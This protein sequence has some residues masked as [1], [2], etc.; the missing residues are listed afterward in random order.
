VPVE[1]YRNQWSG[2]YLAILFNQGGLVAF[3]TPA[4]SWIWFVQLARAESTEPRL[5]VVLLQ[6]DERRWHLVRPS[7]RGY[8]GRRSAHDGVPVVRG[9]PL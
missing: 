2:A 5:R 8:L 6:S 1:S 9:D 7:S 3:G 4:S